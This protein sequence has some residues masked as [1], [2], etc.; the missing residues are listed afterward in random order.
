MYWEEFEVGARYPTYGR[1]V[2]EGDLS[3]F[4]AFV[5]YHVPLFIDE[6]YA[7]TTIYGGRIAPSS[8]TMSISTAMTESLFR[9]S[10][11][12]LLSVD[13]GRFLGP[14]RAGDTIRTEVEVVSKRETRDTSRGVVVFRDHV[15]NQRAE[16]VFEIDKTTLIQRKPL[17]PHTSPLTKT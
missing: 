17:T 13:N 9:N 10:M 14:V 11:V 4:C 3:L 15:L 7:K 12:A 1:T 2:T 16:T 6:E 5:G 8:F